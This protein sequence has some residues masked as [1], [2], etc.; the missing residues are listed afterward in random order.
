[1]MIM[2]L[3]QKIDS[4]KSEVEEQRNLN[5]ESELAIRKAQ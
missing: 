5:A 3:H 1:M 4:L 2:G